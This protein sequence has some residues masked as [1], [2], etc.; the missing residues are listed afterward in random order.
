M[1]RGALSDQQKLIIKALA[2]GL[3][4][5]VEV[6][7]TG[8]GKWGNSHNN[9]SMMLDV[10]NRPQP[11]PLQYRIKPKT[12]SIVVQSVV[13]RGVISREYL[14]TWTSESAVS[15]L[16][17]EKLDTFVR[18]VGEPITVELEVAQ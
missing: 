7:Y 15:R 16:A 18:W 13:R 14:S 8:S 10:V 6:G 2:E 1:T 17:M 9:P 4:L 12:K 11:Y 5:Q 3:Q